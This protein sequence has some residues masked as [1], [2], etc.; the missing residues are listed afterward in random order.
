MFQAQG[1]LWN[2]E[3]RKLTHA[4]NLAL[5]EQE[6]FVL[7]L[8]R[9]RETSTGAKCQLFV[10]TNRVSFFG[11]KFANVESGSEWYSRAQIASGGSRGSLNIKSRWCGIVF[12][13][14]L[15]KIQSDTYWKI[16]K[17]QQNVCGARAK[18]EMEIYQKQRPKMLTFLKSQKHCDELQPLQ[19]SGHW[20]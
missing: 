16:S 11:Y 10:F 2:L 17:T 19:L 20:C 8:S 18:N 13:N 9:C 3:G 5:T 4:S 15:L 12:Y 14:T 6:C 7:F 1:D